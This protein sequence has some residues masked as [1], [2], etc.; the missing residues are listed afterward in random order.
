MKKSK[1]HFLRAGTAG[2]ARRRDV[3]SRVTGKRR[4]VRRVRV[5][6]ARRAVR[7]P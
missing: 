5:Q 6:Q 4:A 3:H 1:A 2:R 7:V